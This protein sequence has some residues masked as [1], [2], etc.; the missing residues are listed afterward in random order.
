[1]KMNKKIRWLI[2]S[3][4]SLAMALVLLLTFSGGAQALML[5]MSLEE[6]TDGADSIVVGTVVST[7]S[8]WNAER[9][10]IYTEVVI[11]VEDS[12]KG[13]AGKN[14]ITV[15][16]EGG[17]VGDI[18]QWVSDTP[19]F[20]AGERIVLFLEELNTAGLAQMGMGAMPQRLAAEHPST[21]YGRFQGKLAVRDQK[22]N[23]LP[24][25]TFK[26]QVSQ[27]MEEQV[28]PDTNTE[29][30]V[31]S[32][33]LPF[34]TLGVT[35]PGVSP[36][37]DYRV[38]ANCGDTTGELAA[39]QSAA[40]TWNNA[41][42]NF[43]FDYG[44]TN[45]R[46]ERLQNYIN[47][48]MWTTRYLGAPGVLALAS[49][50]YSGS[51]IVECDMEFNANY[52]WCVGAQVGKYDI[53]TVGTHEF[54]H[55]VGLDDLYDGADSDKIMYGYI[56]SNTIKR[57]L[58]SDDVNGIR[59]LYGTATPPPA[60]TLTSPANGATVSNTSITF[61]WGS[62]SGATNYH[63]RVGTDAAV[64][65]SIFHSNW[66][67]GVASETYT[68]FPNDGT[69]Y[70]WKVRAYN[71]A[72]WGSWS[73]IRSFNNGTLPLPAAP[74]L[75][76][77]AN[78]ATVANTSITFNWGTV[79][80]ATNYHIRV[81]TD[82]AVETSIFHSNWTYGVASKTYTDF[83]NNGTTYYW[84]V[85]AYNAAGWGSWSE[86]RSFTNGT[87]PL[88][89]APALTSPAN[90]ATV[91]STSVTFNWGSVSGAT[92][93]HIRVGTHP[94]V[95]TSLFHSNY[96]YGTA[97]KTYTDFPNNGT[98]YYWKVRAYNAA[99]WGSWSEIRSFTNGSP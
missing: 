40:T 51:T 69:T 10:G 73:S 62:V 80:T 16:V 70:Y 68:D 79:S 27:A 28:L 7:S 66:T 45:A 2:T 58:H 1:M 6:L 52:T 56:G 44:G 49:V 12:L 96:T 59:S 55:W 15:I 43:G 65:T 22:V 35:W 38:N 77:P 76:S 78:A 92:N 93:Y 42:A 72:G 17:T 61:Q 8:H 32:M 83:P 86:I 75:T 26:Q 34:L 5:E 91:S 74:T 41:G 18:T 39:L 97:S 36:V 20:E 90:G 87:L 14:T 29:R 48:I 25:A 57:S 95:E 89:P 85:R 82:A 24:L 71:A 47:E 33:E 67:Y 98:T 9:T 53:Q 99:G 3:V 13:P 63:I 54:G 84:K 31:V 21:I 94:A 60:P 46:T 50:W 4:L 81:G 37:V 19:V 88:P 64:E 11:S 23:N 30:A